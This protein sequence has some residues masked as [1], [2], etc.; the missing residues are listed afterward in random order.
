MFVYNAAGDIYARTDPYEGAWTLIDSSKCTKVNT[1]TA[2]GNGNGIDLFAR[3]SP[4]V[5]DVAN[6]MSV[7]RNRLSY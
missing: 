5:V 2:V 6:R 3:V 7:Y 1:L 4:N